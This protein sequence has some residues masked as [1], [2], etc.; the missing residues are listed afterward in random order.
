MPSLSVPVVGL[1]KTR[2]DFLRG[3]FATR[4]DRRYWALA[5]GHLYLEAT[6]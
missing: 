5:R 6:R 4:M 3:Y 1:K 2:E